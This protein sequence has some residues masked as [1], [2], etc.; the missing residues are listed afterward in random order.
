[1][2]SPGRSSNHL[3]KH[4]EILRQLK[5]RPGG[6]PSW[7]PGSAQTAQSAATIYSSQT[8]ALNQKLRLFAL[9]IAIN[10]YKSPNFHRLRGAVSDALSF[11]EYLTGHLKIPQEQTTLLLNENATRSA[12]VDALVKLAKDSRIAEGDAIIIYYAGHGGETMPVAGWEA[13]GP[14]SKIQMLVPYDYCAEQDHEIPGI[15]DYVIGALIDSIA[16]KKG[17]NI[18]VIL[19]CCNSASGTR[20]VND[21]VLVRSVELEDD[22]YNPEIDRETLYNGTRGSKPTAR[23][24]QGGSKSHV[25]IAA[26]GS[27]EQAIESNGHGNFSRAFLKL[28]RTISPD[29]LRYCDILKHMDP[30]S[31][32]NPHCEGAN[33]NRILFNRKV[34]PASPECY[35]IRLETNDESPRLILEAGSAHGV[36][37]GAE[38]TAFLRSDTA[39]RQQTAVVSVERTMAFTSVLRIPPGFTFTEE[40]IAVQTRAGRKEDLRLYVNPGDKFRDLFKV[41][42]E[43]TE[44][45]Q[46]CL[47]NITIVGHPNDAHLSARCEK[48]VIFEMKDER[49]TSFGFKRQFDAVDVD[50][51]ASVLGAACH[52]YRTLNREN[53]GPGVARCIQ[54]QFYELQGFDG[55]E[56]RPD[57]TLSPIE[58]DLYRNGV[59][60][61]VVDETACA[62]YGLKITNNSMLD[63]YAYLFYFD[64][65]DLSIASY[66]ETPA[67]CGNYKPDF[68]LKKMG[69]TLTIGYGCGGV[70][71]FSFELSKGQDVDVGFV[72][73][74]VSTMAIDLSRFRQDSPFSSTR[75]MTHW[76]GRPNEAWDSILISVIQRRKKASE[77]RSKK[78]K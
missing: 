57:N 29:K 50:T 45:S 6:M 2:S 33:Q 59:V 68:P 32:Q 12:I 17:D 63:L 60:D 37:V 58:P 7:V 47:D 25:L 54:V 77:N 14:G 11:Q 30:I 9:I 53:N 22:V 40:S 78:S 52:F 1:M 15:P 8:R 4:S 49:A 31:G 10:T 75:T 69:G 19:D 65:T 43:S 61:L 23:F 20:G 26:C 72:K 74:F 70:T 46:Y 28:L 13:G 39:L 71:P 76:P 27:A 34:L 21:D 24:G 38:F 44:N 16:L 56:F 5:T 41:A 36:T 64:L 51:V 55:F 67:A 48:K 73:L 35:P 66:Y 42:C 62:P 3:S 18:T